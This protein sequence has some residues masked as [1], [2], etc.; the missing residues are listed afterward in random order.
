MRNIKKILI[1]LSVFVVFT[2]GFFVDSERG[3][4]SLLI[5]KITNENPEAKVTAYIQAV[6]NGDKEKAL[7]FW[8]IS[9]SY[10]LNSEYQQRIK[11]RGERITKELI[12]K[13]IKSDFAIT[14]IEWWST[15][16]I[17]SVIENSRVAGKAK[18]YVQ[19]T[20]LNNIKS[21]FIFNVI[22]PGG[23]TGVLAGHSVRHWVISDIY[24][25]DEKPVFEY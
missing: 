24:S 5:E 23:Y 1:A 2:I 22:V 13:K 16:C 6:S 15:C 3:V 20:Y 25:K 19:L 21:V 9:E 4:S 7:D 8:N 14:H 12:E 10:E 17:P 11:D 18:V